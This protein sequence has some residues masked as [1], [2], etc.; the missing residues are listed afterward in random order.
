MGSVAGM[1]AFLHMLG[2]CVTQKANAPD[3]RTG[4][5]LL[6]ATHTEAYCKGVAPRPEDRPTARPWQGVLHVRPASEVDARGQAIN[7][8][9]LPV[10]DSI[11]TGADGKGMTTL[12]PGS[13]ILIGHDH[14]D[15][16]HYHHLLKT[17]A[18]AT[19]HRRAI[20]KDCLAQW[21]RGPFPVF[22]ITAG[23]TMRVEHHGHGECSWNSVPCAA[24]MGPLPP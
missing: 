24:W 9:R 5:L 7:D 4:T 21:L 6:H 10:V 18:E 23:H 8:V 14:M 22:T 20:D 11:R 17:H 13:Y 12:P 19:P 2:A 16:R 15:D 1:A 3:E